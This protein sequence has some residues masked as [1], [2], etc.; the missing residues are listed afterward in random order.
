[1]SELSDSTKLIQFIKKFHIK[2]TKLSPTSN[3]MI[4]D[5]INIMENAISSSTFSYKSNILNLSMDFPKGEGY[6]YI[7]P[8]IMKDFENTSKIGKH[9]SFSIGIRTFNIYIIK[10]CDNDND[11]NKKKMYHLID[12]MIHKIYVWLFVC[13]HYANSECSPIINIYIYLTNHKKMLPSFHSPLHTS[14]QLEIDRHNANTAFTLACPHSKNEIYI[15]RFEEW[16]KVLIHESFHSFGLDFAR[17]SQEMVHKKMFSIF[18]INYDL[19][20]YETYC[21]MWAEIINIIFISVNSYSS[22][23]TKIN[24]NK[25]IKTIENHLY[26]EQMFSL[27]QCAK[28]LNFYGLTYRDILQKSNKIHYKEKTSVF[29]YYILKSIVMFYYNDFIEWCY[30]HNNKS[31]EFTKTQNNINQFFEFIKTRYNSDDFINSISIFENWFSNQNQNENHT[32]ILN[33]LRMSI[34]E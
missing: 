33:T 5:I 22:N 23:E 20:F 28:V 4:S 17:M 16:F 21:E 25:L 14:Y 26:I 2:S 19:R 11:D 27:F 34:S 12:K 9:Y 1:M 3:I 8:E 32:F 31:L 30:I 7:T 13:N 18:P 6:D 15:Y 10:P 24:M 29:S